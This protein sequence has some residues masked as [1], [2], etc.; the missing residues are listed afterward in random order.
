MRVAQ[1]VVDGD[2]QRVVNSC[3]AL[4][5][6]KGFAGSARHTRRCRPLVGNVDRSTAAVVI[7]GQLGRAVNADAGGVAASTPCNNPR[8]ISRVLVGDSGP[9][10]GERR[11]ASPVTSRTCLPRQRALA[12]RFVWS[13]VA[14]CR[15][16]NISYR[17]LD[18]RQI[19]SRTQIARQAL[20]LRI[21]DVV[22]LVGKELTVTRIKHVATCID[23]PEHTLRR[24]QSPY[25]TGCRCSTRSRS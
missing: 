6:S 21:D 20:T 1:G 16:R 3:L 19:G 8:F 14:R 18:R 5:G 23:H 22:V 2:G 11:Q 12:F 17:H 15:R 10:D 25:R 24:H 4:S 7:R 9:L 13:Y